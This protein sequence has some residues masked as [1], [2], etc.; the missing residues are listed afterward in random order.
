MLGIR[1]LLKNIVEA[2]PKSRNDTEYVYIYIGSRGHAQKHSRG[3]AQKQKIIL[4]IY[5]L[6][7]KATIK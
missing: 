4:K 3:H 5:I 7:V 6:G 1:A 2:M